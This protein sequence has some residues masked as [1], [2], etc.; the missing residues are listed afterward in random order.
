MK[1]QVACTVADDD[2]T[3]SNDKDVKLKFNCRLT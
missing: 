2:Y 3:D 1:L